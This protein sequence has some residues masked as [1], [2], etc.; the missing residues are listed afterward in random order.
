MDMDKP[1]P[2]FKSVLDA[3]ESYY[4]GQITLEELL[5]FSQQETDEALTAYKHMSDKSPDKKK[6]GNAQKAGIIAQIFG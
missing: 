6:K 3:L 2:K 1:I 5:D 4:A